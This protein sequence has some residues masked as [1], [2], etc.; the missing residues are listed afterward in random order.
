MHVSINDRVVCFFFFIAGARCHVSS[1]G[2]QS[3]SSIWLHTDIAKVICQSSICLHHF[4]SPHGLSIMWLWTYMPLCVWLTTMI[5]LHIL[6]SSHSFHLSLSMPLH[7]LR[8]PMFFLRFRFATDRMQASSQ[9]HNRVRNEIRAKTF[10]V[11]S[12]RSHGLSL[13]AHLYDSLS[14]I[15]YFY[16]NHLSSLDS[17]LMIVRQQQE[18][19]LMLQQ[20]Q[21]TNK[22]NH[23]EWS[24]TKK[25]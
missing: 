14:F 6:S 22:K 5:L 2:H 18:H 3:K 12:P 8:F 17:A 11:Q 25:N 4:L 7:P 9:E 16:E 20:Q 13:L 21:K 15:A 24:S 19:A 1:V 23:R 10:V